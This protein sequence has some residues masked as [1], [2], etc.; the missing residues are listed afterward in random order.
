MHQLLESVLAILIYY[1]I[2]NCLTIVI[3]GQ[4]RAY[5]GRQQRRQVAEQA[6]DDEGTYLPL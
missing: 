1:V 3:R 4:L 2:D 5:W 6:E